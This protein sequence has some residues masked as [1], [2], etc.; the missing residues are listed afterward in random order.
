[1]A[2]IDNLFVVYIVLFIDYNLFWWLLQL[3]LRL[4]CLPFCFSNL[5]FIINVV[6]SKYRELEV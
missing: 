4:L 2:L 5:V 3:R 6:C 1:L